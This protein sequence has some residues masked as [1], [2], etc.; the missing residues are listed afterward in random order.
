M[1]G[2]TRHPAAYPAG[3]YSGVY[4]QPPPPPEPPQRSDLPFTILLVVAIVI[5]L[6]GGG[7]VVVVGYGQYRAGPSGTAVP[8]PVNAPGTAHTGDLRAL[9]LSRPPGAVPCPRSPGTNETLTA[10]QWSALDDRYVAEVRDDLTRHGFQR[11]AVRCW[12]TAGMGVVIVLAQLDTAQHAAALAT[13]D[14]APDKGMHK[15]VSPAGVPGGLTFVSDK[16]DARGQ[17]GVFSA[18][19]RGDITI[20]VVVEQ[21]PPD[22]PSAATAL[23]RQQYD[24]L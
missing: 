1:Y 9:L 21:L 8:L 10:E 3:G 13:E 12:G 2:T 24:R 18:A 7:L 19:Q 16:P 6:I 20:V 4:F 17:I 5:V 23:L 15:L 11:A 14:P 22:D